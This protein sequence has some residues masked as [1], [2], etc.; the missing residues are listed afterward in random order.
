MQYEIFSLQGLKE[1]LVGAITT[2]P[3]EPIDTK[4]IC[5]TRSP[6]YAASRPQN[7]ARLLSTS[8]WASLDAYLLP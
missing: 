7:P 4:R 5:M 3:A 8:R 1:I 2:E 6:S